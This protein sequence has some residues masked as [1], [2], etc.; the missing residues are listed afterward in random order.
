ML[1]Q[2]PAVAVTGPRQSGK[3]T[4]LKH[5]LP[6]AAYRS[7]DDPQVRRL[8]EE[9]PRLF[10]DTPGEQ[11]LVD[12]VQYAPALL[13]HVKL[14]ID[15]R[16]DVRGRFVLTGSQQFHL[17]KGL[18]DSLAGRVGILELPPFGAKEVMRAGADP[19]PKP[20][21]LQA[22][23]RGMFPELV[24]T[25]TLNS[26]HWYGAYVQ[27]YIERDV[28]SLY[29]IGGLREFERFLMLLA[30][31]CGQALNLSA[32]ASDVGVAVNT[33]KRWI[34]ILEAGRIV[35]LLPPY[36]NNL[37]KRVTKSPKVYFLDCGIVCYLT[38]L[39]DPEHLLRGPLA[40]PL[41]ENY[42]VQE[43][44][45]V[46]LSLG[47]RPRLYYLRTK[48]GLEVDLLVEGADGRLRPF[49]IKLTETPRLEMGAPLIRVREEFAALNME[50]GGLVTLAGVAPMLSRDFTVLTVA[51]F[52]SAVAEIVRG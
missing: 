11:L 8:A 49:E 1:Q 39:R 46:S 44:V 32:L 7:L 14:R 22:C 43:A 47:V 35:F 40:G 48:A 21:F 24:T 30:A 18:G 3:S 38:G 42:C 6:D 12:E 9:D 17:I 45:K 20:A 13:S 36:Y 34:S 29:D 4:L 27:T 25:P 23:L 51:D 31:R 2:F 19:N 37:G 50:S 5:A 10:L 15:E 52:L 26:A 28:R 41:F 16:R 33:I